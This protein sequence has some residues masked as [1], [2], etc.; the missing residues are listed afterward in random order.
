MAAIT[1]LMVKELREKSGAGMLECKKALEQTGGDMAK[2]MDTLREKGIA[3]ASKK[4]G[5]AANEGLVGFKLSADGKSAVLVEVMCETDFVARTADFQ[6]LVASLA[7][8]GLAASLSAD[9]AQ[10]AAELLALP[11]K[12]LAGQ[13]VADEIKAVIGKLGENMSLGRVARI[14]GEGGLLGSYVHAD[15]K[16]AAVVALKA[17]K[18]GDPA[19]AQLAR[20]LAMQVA[21]N[22]PAAQVVRREQVP[23]AF[24]A[25]EQ[26]IAMAQARETG[27]PAAILPKIAQGKVNKVL[28][29]ITLLEQAFVK[30]PTLT[31]QALVDQVAKQAGDKLSVESF[32]RVRVGEK[33]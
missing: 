14:H 27:K 24:L 11:S 29:E 19:V 26:E 18:P 13:T 17:G 8:Q 7:Q 16:L 2:A 12:A 31:I 28:Q 1:A 32:I 9:P 20:D 15:N 6:G 4:A 5:R 21:G 10:A 33:A 22:I 30:E 23:A 25:K 3:S